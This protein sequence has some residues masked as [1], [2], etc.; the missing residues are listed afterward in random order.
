MLQASVIQRIQTV[1]VAERPI[2]VL[3][4]DAGPMAFAG[5]RRLLSTEDP[6]LPLTGEPA[7]SR[8][9]IVPQGS[10][11]IPEIEAVGLSNTLPA[12]RIATVERVKTS[13]AF[14]MQIES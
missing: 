4:T 6:V 12:A 13:V 1:V 2:S 3:T 14:G 8:A 10:T 11:V 5:R 9:E 7:A